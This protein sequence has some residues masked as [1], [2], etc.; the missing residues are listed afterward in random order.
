MFSKDHFY[1]F[2]KSHK[3]IQQTKRNSVVNL[4]YFSNKYPWRDSGAESPI[5]LFDT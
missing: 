2:I 1:Y 4:S 5:I 3:N